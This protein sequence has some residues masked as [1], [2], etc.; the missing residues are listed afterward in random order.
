MFGHFF[1]DGQHFP[2]R[3]V[4]DLHISMHSRTTCLR[5]NQLAVLHD[6]HQLIIVPFDGGLTWSYIIGKSCGFNIIGSPHLR[7]GSLPR[8]LLQWAVPE[9]LRLH[10]SFILLQKTHLPYDRC[11][12]RSKHHYTKVSIIVNVSFPA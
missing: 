4:G 11:V 12:Y 7:C 1:V 8:H 2:F 6:L 5:G 10:S 9:L 3:L